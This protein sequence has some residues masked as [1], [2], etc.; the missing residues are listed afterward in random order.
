MYYIRIGIENTMNMIKLLVGQLQSPH[1]HILPTAI[2]VTVSSLLSIAVLVGLVPM[3]KD[4]SV[5]ET[6]SGSFHF[7]IAICLWAVP[8]RY[9]VKKRT[10]FVVSCICIQFYW[11]R[12]YPVE[13][14]CVLC[15]WENTKQ[16]NIVEVVATIIVGSLFKP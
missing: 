15:D 7:H 5:F 14:D 4:P 9:T 16:H 11:T 1:T 13:L 2:A 3:V 6:Q 12:L 8:S 10:C